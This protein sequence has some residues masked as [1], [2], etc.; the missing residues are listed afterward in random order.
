MAQAVRKSVKENKAEHPFNM[1]QV[2]YFQNVLR[3][4]FADPDNSYVGIMCGGKSK[5]VSV[6][7][8][9]EHYQWW[10][11]KNSCYMTGNL[12][13]P[14]KR[15]CQ[16]NVCVLNDIYI[17]LDTNHDEGSRFVSPMQAYE[18]VL[19]VVKEKALP[20][21]SLIVNT[22]R[23][24]QLH[25][26]LERV[27]TTKN[28]IALWKKIE[29]AL[30]DVFADF[31]PD[32]TVATDESRLL[33]IPY[34]INMKSGCMAEI[35]DF[36]KERYSLRDFKEALFDNAPTK[37]Q[38]DYIARIEE[39]LGITFPD[40][41]KNT[42]KNASTTIKLNKEEFLQKIGCDE[43]ES[44]VS[45]KQQEL[46][47]N[48]CG[49]LGV[50]NP[51]SRTY[52]T[53]DKFI[54]S[55]MPAYRTAKQNMG[56][57][58]ANREK[59]NAEVMEAFVE[60]HPQNDH[61]RENLL[62][63]YRL[64]QMHVLGDEG[65]AWE[66]TAQLNK[67]YDS[68]FN[69]RRLERLTHSAVNYFMY[70]PERQYCTK[71]IV[72][73][74]GSD[75][76][77]FF[78]RPCKGKSKGENEKVEKEKKQK[79]KAYNKKYYESKRK[80]ESKAEKIAKRREAVK[81]L[82]ANGLS[83]TEISKALQVCTK[84]VQRDVE[85]IKNFVNVDVKQVVDVETEKFVKKEEIEENVD[86]FSVTPL[87]YNTVGIKEED[88]AEEKPVSV[89]GKHYTQAH[90]ARAF[91]MLSN[92]LHHNYDHLTDQSHT[93]VLLNALRT[94]TLISE[95]VNVC[96][97]TLLCISNYGNRIDSSPSVGSVG[98][99]IIDFAIAGDGSLSNLFTSVASLMGVQNKEDCV[100]LL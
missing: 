75:I 47:G 24:L 42:K 41:Y 21:P 33:R 35:L 85:S 25:W 1:M 18:E 14:D 61:C 37:S 11:C 29:T 38:L 93:H 49:T 65:K 78:T 86:I 80:G 58:L 45:E 12:I 82:M 96:D 66:K 72:N 67:V 30:C 95:G 23:G 27:A 9:L 100:A 54:R 46:I 71:A 91:Q 69:E 48:I 2:T 94:A 26:F 15:R 59:A 22:T 98:K 74:V 62:F 5:T 43:K 17:D 4:M 7:D 64:A 40:N 52:R 90:L 57:R 89:G 92:R 56:A 44:L 32:A 3:E 36:N 28:R 50:R 31:C 8:L 73:K 10:Y 13:W 87:L 63:L 20:Y 83:Y 6:G 39:A 68:P 76:A 16:K 77:S 99:A 34:S 79:R 60:A 53:A 97:K 55:H 81:E 84:T 70:E 19:D 51:G 88:T